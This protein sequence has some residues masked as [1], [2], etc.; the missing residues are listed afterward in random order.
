M[1]RLSSSRTENYSYDS[2]GRVTAV[3]YGHAIAGCPAANLIQYS[4]DTEGNRLTQTTAGT[5]TDYSYNAADQ[6]TQAAVQGGATTSYSY[7]ANGNE[8]TAGSRSFSYDEANRVTQISD[9][10][11]TLDS[12]S[13]DGLG[14]RL[15]KTTPSGTTSYLWDVNASLPSLAE[16]LNGSTLLRG[17]AYGDD[18]GQG[19][20]QL[21]MT[22]GTGTY[23]F[24]TDGLG[25]TAA[26]TD[27]SGQIEWRYTYDPYGNPRT[28]D[29]VDPTA[30][31]NV[32]GFAGQLLDPETGL[33]DMRARLYDPSTGRFLS[34]DPSPLPPTQP[35]VGLYIY[36]NDDPSLQT[37]DS[38]QVAIKCKKCVK[39]V[40]CPP[41]WTKIKI[42]NTED[43][44]PPYK[45]VFNTNTNPLKVTPLPAK[46]QAEIASV[47]SSKTT[48]F[49]LIKTGPTGLSLTLGATTNHRPSV[50]IKASASSSKGGLG[51]KIKAG[52][53]A[54][55]GLFSLFVDRT[56]I[57]DILSNAGRDGQAARANA[58]A[59]E[60]TGAVLRGTNTP[61]QLTS[62]G[63]FRIGTQQSMWENAAD[64]PT[65]G[66]LCPS[67]GTEVR[68]AP[69]S[70]PR[71]WDGSHN[72][73][74]TNRA[75]PPDVTRSE[76]LDNY[77]R[78]TFLECP[79]CSRSG[80]NNDSRFYG[81]P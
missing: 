7:D 36:A 61:G 60:D 1:S 57:V 50:N 29:K 13:Y 64:G 67:C 77:Q 17:Y 42:G 59:A 79:T 25:S 9:G 16:E 35:A 10:T 23:Y 39:T 21:S 71:D 55:A 24:S 34:I 74:W 2:S 43:C 56:G 19:L 28:T 31:A 11:T 27:Q 68:V 48:S 51:G 81:G 72:P 75:F 66:R 8:L 40:V 49:A 38:G 18:N 6:L 44:L 69:G 4:Y 12:F 33:Y 80:G 76:V 37:D 62:R 78:D 52:A 20:D 15:T 14:N 63:S 46:V 58:A 47:E 73:S 53:G 54:V 32:V 41:G 65:G 45:P 5:T 30:P 22:S 70:G 3:C 26:I